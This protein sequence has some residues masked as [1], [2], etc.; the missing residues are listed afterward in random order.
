MPDSLEALRR[1]GAPVDLLPEAY[2]QVFAELSQHEVEVVSS[3]QTRLNAAGGDV[4]AQE[5]V[6]FLC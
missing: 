4:E 5:I 3:V 2:R 1:A 6:N